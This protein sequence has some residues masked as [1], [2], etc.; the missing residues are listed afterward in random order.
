M[1]P[2]HFLLLED[3]DLIQ[4]AGIGVG[5]RPETRCQ[6][7]SEQWARLKKV[8]LAAVLL[9]TVS[10]CASKPGEDQPLPTDVL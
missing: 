4:E 9:G 1:E 8:K 10:G 7:T 2:P 5:S 3:G 6:R